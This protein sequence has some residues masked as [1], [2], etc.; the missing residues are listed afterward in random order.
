VGE[1]TSINYIT[2]QVYLAWNVTHY[3]L[4]VSHHWE[5]IQLEVL[6]SEPGRLQV[7]ALTPPLPIG[8]AD[9]VLNYIAADKEKQG[10]P[11][12][13]ARGAV[14]PGIKTG[15]WRSIFWTIL[16]LLSKGFW[17]RSQE[18]DW[19]RPKS[20]NQLLRQRFELACRALSSLDLKFLGPGL[21]LKEY[22]IQIYKGVPAHVKNDYPDPRFA[23]DLNWVRSF[24]AGRALLAKDVRSLLTGE[25]EH[26]P[27]SL[28]KQP[29]SQGVMEAW[30]PERFRDVYQVLVLRGEGRLLP[31]V[32][33]DLRGQPVCY[34]CGQSSRLQTSV[35]GHCGRLGCYYC[36]S[37]SSMGVSRECLPFYVLPG[38]KPTKSRLLGEIKLSFDLTLAQ[39][40]AAQEVRQYVFKESS[41]PCLVWAVCGA[42]KTEV[43]F[44]ALREVLTGGGRVLYA[45]PRRDV[46][47]EIYPR[48]QQAFPSCRV[49]A[50]YAGSR[51]RYR[52]GSDMA[53]II[54]AT[55]H[56]ALRYYQNFDLV[57]L[58]EADAYPYRDSSLLHYAVLRAV[59]PGGKTVYLTATPTQTM[60]KQARAKEMDLIFIP[61]RHHGYPVPEPE[62]ISESRLKYPGEDKVSGLVLPST[63]ID[64]I[65]Q[66]VV[67]EQRQLFIFVPA[68]N[69][70]ELAFEAVR[71]I[72]A[73]STIFNQVYPWWHKEPRLDLKSSK[74]AKIQW[75]QF[76]HAK[77]PERDQKRL[78]FTKAEFPI[79]ITTTILERGVT[80]PRVNVLVLF[81]DAE[82]IFD[83]GSLIQ[84][85]G[86][87]GR[88]TEDPR[89]K[90][91]LVGRSISLAMRSAVRRIRE[92]NQLARVLGYLKE[93][94]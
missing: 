83:E 1:S 61:A 28:L 12:T 47:Q 45:I 68:V 27:V 81:A 40:K 78:G 91:W 58:D 77:D 3:R 11:L 88:T 8:I 9:F 7:S 22:P 46:V 76:S 32:G 33:R 65:Y 94:S 90:A 41:G 13:W 5:N 52:P 35:C 75:V 86:R 37:C 85:S 64:L 84:M 36:E 51:D 63:V 39:Q 66:T 4:F 29:R 70:T 50:L 93:N 44:S 18:A 74:E 21:D 56:Q 73:K 24:F 72:I 42:G 92:M 26:I 49:W 89:G 30:V 59:R 6:G 38:L 17:S 16:A 15:V 54:V 67:V 23:G 34:R 19:A 43:V 57:I 20:V 60:Q 87:T 71:Q 69:L 53:D 79:L 31:S 2:Y 10:V 55:T 25:G 62:L 82:K 48:L 14:P 80:I